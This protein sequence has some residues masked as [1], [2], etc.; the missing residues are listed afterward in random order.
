MDIHHIPTITIAEPSND[1]KVFLLAPE[2]VFIVPMGILGNEEV[3]IKN[4]ATKTIAVS[5]SREN[6]LSKASERKT[7]R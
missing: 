2:M 1:R 3:A 4:T 7:P 5:I 6:P